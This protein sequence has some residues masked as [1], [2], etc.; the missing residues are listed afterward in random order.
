MCDISSLY[1]D[2]GYMFFNVNPKE[3]A[4]IGDSIDIEIR[5]SEGPQATIKNVI[6]KG[7]DKTSEHV[8]RREIRTKPG[9]KFSRTALIRSQRELAN[10]GFFDAEQ[11]GVVP[12]PNPVDGTVDI[13]YTVVEKSA[14]QIELSAGW[15]GNQGL[16]GT[17]GL[18]FNN[19]SLKNMFRKGSWSP[20]PTGDGQ[21]FSLRIQS[22]C[23]ELFFS[24]LCTSPNEYL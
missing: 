14:D 17:L 21:K 20:L 11:I 8:I 22:I 10:L 5:I 6:I 19:F 24:P 13:E 2:D 3:V 18:S 9:D 4:I 12:I 15:G 23:V 1:Y 16:I 7:N